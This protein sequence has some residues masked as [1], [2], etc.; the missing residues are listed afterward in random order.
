MLDFF[1]ANEKDSSGLPID[2]AIKNLHFECV[3]ILAPLT[4][5]LKIDEKFSTSATKMTN[6]SNFLQSIIDERQGTTK[7]KMDENYC[8]NTT[9]KIKVELRNDKLYEFPFENDSK[10]FTKDQIERMIHLFNL[11]QNKNS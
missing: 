6:I 3:K 2:G 8:I 10:V 11:D 4:K 5:D 1:D 7:R 9:K